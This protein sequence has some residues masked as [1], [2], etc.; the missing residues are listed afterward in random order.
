MII[1]LLEPLLVDEKIIKELSKKFKEEGYVFVAYHKKPNGID[2]LIERIEDADIVIIGNYPLPNDVIRKA[3][4]LK[5]I[6]V[7]FTG[8]DHIGLEAVKEKNI[9][10]CNSA[11][12]SDISVSEL[13]LGFAINLL[14]NVLE[15]DNS[16]RK[17]GTNKGMFGNQLYGKTVG[18]VGCGKIG[19]KTANLYNAFNC[20]VIGYDPYV[21]EEE[22]K[23]NNIKKVNID[24]LLSDSDVISLH[25]PSN[26]ET[27]NF[28]DK[29]KLLKMKETA[30]LINVARGAVVDNNALADALNEGVI[31]SAAIDVFD[32]EPPIPT[33]YKLLK[34]RNTLFTPHVAYGT[35][36]SMILR[37]EFA[38]NNVYEYIDGKEMKN[39][40]NVC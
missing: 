14:R 10:L 13:S 20:D 17:R 32:M 23:S 3:K 9:T 37:A 25:L 16:T 33:E 1:K 15:G 29:E 12:Y 36:E 40:I 2:E 26:E 30:I 24:K 18:I 39:K 34:A 38:F 4:N 8:Y 11:G 28:I 27:L 5:M 21:S 31:R 6:S 7:A 35:K 19:K 22:L